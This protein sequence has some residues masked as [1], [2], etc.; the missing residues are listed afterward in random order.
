MRGQATRTAVVNFLV[1]KAESSDGTQRLPWTT[2]EGPC[3]GSAETR[4]TACFA[5]LNRVSHV[6]IVPGAR[7]ERGCW[8]PWC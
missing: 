5:F 2:D 4:W 6:R 8:S 1:N 7:S 3:D